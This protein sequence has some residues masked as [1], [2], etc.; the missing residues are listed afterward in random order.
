MNTLK[1]INDHIYALCVPYKDIFT[2]V[3]FVKTES[4]VL[5]FDTASYDS[6]V[7][8]AI[9][10]ALRELGVGE[11]DFKYVFISHN[12]TD[13]AGGLC[14][15]LEAYPKVCVVSKSEAL[16]EK[17]AGYTFLMPN[18]GETL[19]DILSVV[20]IMGH[21]KDSAAIYDSRTKTLIS[22]DC[23]Q[24]YGIFGSGCWGANISFS[25]EYAAAIEKLR[26]MDIDAILTAHDYHPC[27][28]MYFGKAEITA[29][30]DAC[31]VPFEIIKKLIED[32]PDASDEIICEKYNSQNDLPRLGAHVVRKYRESGERL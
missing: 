1:K 26:K 32:D 10:P 18:E 8:N 24:L 3:Y 4:G 13:H 11:D 25:T 5:L 19:L 14:K 9:I 16:R 29:A 28:R 17:F 27:G 23:L 2:T 15:L 31:L 7:E 20:S 30:L 6:D 22:G 12:H 21:T